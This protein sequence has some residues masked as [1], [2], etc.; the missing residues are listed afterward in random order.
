MPGRCVG[1]E[2]GGCRVGVLGRRVSV[3][4]EEGVGGTQVALHN[5]L[6]HTM[7]NV[8]L[9]TCVPTCSCWY[10]YMFDVF[11]YPQKNAVLIPHGWD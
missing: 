7:H 11:R 9:R 10:M 2:E 3:G 5:I 8:F 6:T 1:G 4:G